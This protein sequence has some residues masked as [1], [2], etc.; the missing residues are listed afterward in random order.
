MT[1]YATA[2]KGFRAGRIVFVAC[3]VWL[4]FGRSAAFSQP[5]QEKAWE[6]LQGG[7]NEHNTTKRAAAARA[8]R[9]L[10]G[11]SRA[12]DFAETA[13]RD[14]KP[15]VRAAAATALG[16]L[17]ARSSISQLKVALGDKDNRVFY[18]AADSL[19]LLGDPAGYDAY[20]QQLTGE[21]KSGEGMIPTK[22]K[23][24][25]DPK[26]LTLLAVGVG[27]G[28]A[29]YAT[30]GWMVWKE[31]SV[32]YTSPTRIKAL[33]KLEN[34]PDSGIITALLKAASDKHWTVRVAALSAIAR[35][36]DVSLI[37]PI[38]PYMADKEAAVRY[39]AAA[40]ILKLS[41]W[42]PTDDT[43]QSGNE[44]LRSQIPTSEK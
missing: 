38:T 43:L 34:D 35:R 1:N 26:A 18:A 40:A 11:N 16:Q 19:I 32:D 12:I 20:Y 25:T 9:F 31:L 22:K 41:A 4:T 7:L 17:G 3:W 15:A 13:L 23:F 24:I 42:V 33:S 39:T 2:A 27:I 21:R 30:Y 36:G 28:Y 29:P 8:L 44:E 10:E 6:V 5:P 37:G 14:K